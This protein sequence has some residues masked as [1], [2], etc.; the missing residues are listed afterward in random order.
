MV[1]IGKCIIIIIVKPN[2]FHIIKCSSI[3]LFKIFSNENILLITITIYKYYINTIL[4][5]ITI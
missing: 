4:P 5:T 1:L 3:L 2:I